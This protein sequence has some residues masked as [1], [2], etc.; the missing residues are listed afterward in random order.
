M[1]IPVELLRKLTMAETECLTRLTT[2]RLIQDY[3]DSL[4]YPSGE[5]N[6]SVL[7]VVQEKQAHCL[8]GG[9]FAAAALGWLGYSPLILDLIPEAGQDDDHVLALFQ[10]EGYWG[11]LAK[12]NFTCLR[13]REPVFRTL[14][15]LVL[16]YFSDFFNIKGNLTL[17]AY[18]RPIALRKWNHWNWLLED[19]GV[20]K[21]EA[22]LKSIPARPLFPPEVVAGLNPVDEITYRQGLARANWSGLFNPDAPH[23]T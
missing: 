2:P 21:I 4:Q 5:K 23:T 8:D 13:M 6:R 18:T 17:R 16:S 20:D 15:E 7:H 14:R 9:L 12:S 11:A 1:Q 10:V 3:L 19:S 22:A